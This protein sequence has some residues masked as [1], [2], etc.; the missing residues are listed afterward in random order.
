MKRAVW[1]KYWPALVFALSNV[2][3]VGLVLQA[4]RSYRNATSTSAYEAEDPLAWT[5]PDDDLFPPL[6]DAQPTDDTAP[7]LLDWG[8]DFDVEASA[9]NRR[10]GA[11]GLIN[12]VGSR[13]RGLRQRV[14]DAAR[15]DRRREREAALVNRR[16]MTFDIIERG[17]GAR[18]GSRTVLADW[19]SLPPLPDPDDLFGGNPLANLRPAG[20]DRVFVYVDPTLFKDQAAVNTFVANLAR[21]LQQQ[22]LSPDI[23]LQRATSAVG[24]LTPNAGAM[25]PAVAAAPSIPPA[26]GDPGAPSSGGPGGRMTPLPPP[27]AGVRPSSPPPVP[28]AGA[29]PSVPPAAG[30]QGPTTPRPTPPRAG[31]ANAAPTVPSPTPPPAEA[32]GS[33]P[34]GGEAERD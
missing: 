21:N 32:P 7:L 24:A 5:R 3:A 2:V 33:F 34:V 25:P 4:H 18:L 17:T 20:R 11:N 14:A 23:A 22:G 26:I 15:L 31:G 16:P 10:D 13:L 6:D 9:P 8:Q 28:V 27:P 30:G 19:E 29:G 12:Q 1:L